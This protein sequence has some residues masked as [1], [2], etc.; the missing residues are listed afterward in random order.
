GQAGR[1][2]TP[3]SRTPRSRPSSVQEE[4]KEELTAVTRPRRSGEADPNAELTAGADASLPGANELMR[5]IT[6]FATLDDGRQPFRMVWVSKRLA[7]SGIALDAAEQLAKRAIAV[8]DQATEPNASMRDAPLLDRAGRLAV[9]MGRAQDA[10]GWTLLK[11]GD[12]RGAIQNLVQ[13]IDSFPPSA[14]RKAA[15]WHLGVAM[16]EAGDEPRALDFYIAAYQ[17]DLPNSAAR[18]KR[19]EALYKKVKG[20]TDGLDQRLTPP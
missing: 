19:I 7:E 1:R 6:L 5:A 11:K 18:R 14:E 20:S 4:P 3:A 8:A 15:L 13:S 10:L 2:R 16:E 17:P 9:F 12:T